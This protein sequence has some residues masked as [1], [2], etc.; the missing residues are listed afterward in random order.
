M[1][2]VHCVICSPSCFLKTELLKY[3]HVCMCVFT[4][5]FHKCG[6]DTWSVT[7]EIDCSLAL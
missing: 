5:Y 6:S 7:V 2:L 3:K 1:Q 4:Y